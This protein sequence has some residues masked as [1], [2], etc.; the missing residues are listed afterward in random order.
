MSR[1]RQDQVA[2]MLHEGRVVSEK[3]NNTTRIFFPFSSFLSLHVFLFSL[4]S[5]TYSDSRILK[6]H[7]CLASYDQ[8]YD[9]FNNT[10]GLYQDPNLLNPFIYSQ[11]RGTIALS[12]CSE[13][14][15]QT[16]QSNTRIA[17]DTTPSIETYCSR[18]YEQSERKHVQPD[19]LGNM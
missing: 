1:R 8:I 5:S 12:V 10:T 11:S 7:S 16:T 14:S 3:H 18:L 15:K 17:R 13:P 4:F 2:T 6:I 19:K 9:W